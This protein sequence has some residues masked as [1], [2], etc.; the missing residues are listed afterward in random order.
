MTYVFGFRAFSRKCLVIEVINSLIIL[1]KIVLKNMEGE[2]KETV[3]ANSF[4]LSNGD[5]IL[6][7]YLVREITIIVRKNYRI[8]LV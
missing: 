1:K 6:K 3:N 2:V 5:K 4:R 7:K 8:Q